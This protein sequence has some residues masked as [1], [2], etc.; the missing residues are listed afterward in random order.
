[1]GATIV[2]AFIEAMVLA[3]ISIAILLW[4]VLRRI[5]D[6][7]VTLIPLMVAGLIT[8]EICSLQ[9]FS[10]TMPTSS[11]FLCC[12]ASAWRSRSIT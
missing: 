9:I 11:P 1:M 10:S 4:L 2:E 12:S 8:L 5:T 3:L 7:L 6:V